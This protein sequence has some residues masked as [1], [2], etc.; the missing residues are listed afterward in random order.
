VKWPWVNRSA[1]IRARSLRNS[2]IVDL[3]RQVDEARGAREELREALRRSEV[4]RSDLQMSLLRVG[5]GYAPFAVPEP[6]AAPTPEPITP[7]D[8]LDAITPGMSAEQV[9]RIFTEEAVGKYGNN[10]RKIRDHVEQRQEDYY[11]FRNRAPILSE[12]EKAAAAAVAA[13]VEAAIAE[14]RAEAEKA[15]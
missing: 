4:E 6:V 7:S 5:F 8:P 9:Q 13:D 15:A 14:G 1:I 10:L 12:R 11:R 3:R 2:E